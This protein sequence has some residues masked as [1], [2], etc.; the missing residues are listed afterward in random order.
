MLIAMDINALLL[1]E[2]D[3][4]LK[5]TRAALERVP[6]QP[7][8]AAHPKSMPL[9]N[10]A[11]HVAQL[12]EFGVLVLT[13]PGLDFATA[14]FQRLPFESAAQLVAAFDTGAARVRS[15]LT[16]ATENS[17]SANWKLSHGSA[18]LFEG[19]R[20]V[21]YR[22]M[23]LNHLVHHRAQLGVY[24]RLLNVAVPRTYGPSADEQ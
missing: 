22:Q 9:K 7:D 10:L 13:T 5:A 21:A 8:F 15:A 11:P 12:P 23:F 3:S 18:T 17:W 14:Q 1:A 4:E 19:S 6:N 16:A 2:F 24:L 20:F